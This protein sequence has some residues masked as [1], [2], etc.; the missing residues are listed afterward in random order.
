MGN[1]VTGIYRALEQAD[2][3]HRAQVELFKNQSQVSI[4]NGIELV[5]ELQP[6]FAHGNE[7]PNVA[8]TMQVL[9]SSPPAYMGR[10]ARRSGLLSI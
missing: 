6:F 5:R 2:G 10:P 7:Q 1:E 4:G 8:A 9:L 3:A